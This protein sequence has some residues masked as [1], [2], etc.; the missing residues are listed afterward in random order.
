VQGFS[1]TK[2]KNDGGEREKSGQAEVEICYSGG[3]MRDVRRTGKILCG[4]DIFITHTPRK[5]RFYPVFF[6][7]I[8]FTVFLTAGVFFSAVPS[9]LPVS[10]RAPT[11]SEASLVSSPLL[12]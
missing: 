8:F 3:G 7:V 1:V 6:F 11:R 9:L 12:F 10:P 2:K 4:S 5:I